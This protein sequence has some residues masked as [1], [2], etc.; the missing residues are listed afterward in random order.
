VALS[1]SAV[2][3]FSEYT[4]LYAKTASASHRVAGSA[5]SGGPRALATSSFRSSGPAASLTCAGA[6]YCL[7]R[8]RQ[9]LAEGLPH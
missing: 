7:R 8:Q 9:V 6:H 5:K 2:F 4:F 3:T 1:D